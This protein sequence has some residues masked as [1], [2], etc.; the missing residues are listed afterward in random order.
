MGGTVAWEMAVRAPERDVEIAG[1]ILIDSDL[2]NAKDPDAVERELPGSFAEQLGVSP[3]NATLGGIARMTATEQLSAP[4][5]LVAGDVPLSRAEPEAL[6]A[7]FRVFRSN[8]HA[9]S[10][11]IPRPLD[12]P[13]LLV[14]AADPP[15][16]PADLGW[17]GYALGP[18]QIEP[19]PGT[20][21]TLLHSSRLEPIGL[22]HK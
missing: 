4:R 3:S 16:R 17:Q 6:T 7:M 13:V 1:V 18:L 10:R 15:G 5:R 20:H 11:W 19:L 22:G 9:Q 21:N 14:V 8:Y 2:G 12:V